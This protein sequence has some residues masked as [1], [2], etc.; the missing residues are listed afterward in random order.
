MAETSFEYINN[1]SL[2]GFIEYGKAA[3]I[4]GQSN[5]SRVDEGFKMREVRHGV[6]AA[7]TRYVR[8][9]KVDQLEIQRAQGVGLQVQ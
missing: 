4:S 8:T 2:S 6:S 5:E 1:H 9:V 3:I 7:F